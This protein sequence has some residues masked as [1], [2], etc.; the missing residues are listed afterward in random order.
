MATAVAL[1]SAGRPADA[2]RT[3]A[4][5][6][7]ARAQGRRCAADAV[8]RSTCR[9][10][11]TAEA[12]KHLLAVLDLQPADPIALNNLA[13]I[14][15]SRD[16][17]RAMAMARKG[18]LLAP[19]PQSADT[20][21]WILT[22][23]GDA[24]TGLLLLTQAAANLSTDAAI[25]Y[26]LA[27]ALNDTGQKDKAVELLTKLVNSPAEFDD[28]PAARKLLADLGGPKQP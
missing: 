8:H 6:A 15:Q 11:R 19:G 21:G 18:Y 10:G 25:F 14:Y 5:L 24:K 13:W 27:V 16:D 4:E 20:L 7:A 3:A 26:H 1:E 2:Q 22:K 9:A 17:P 28:K 23:Q 12:E